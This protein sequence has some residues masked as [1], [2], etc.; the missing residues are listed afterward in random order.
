[1]NE[2]LALLFMLN[3]ITTAI[4]QLLIFYILGNHDFSNKEG[5]NRKDNAKT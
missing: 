3:I 4:A 2:I 5:T 1:M